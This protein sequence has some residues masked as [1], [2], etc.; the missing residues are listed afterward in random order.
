MKNG[1]KTK[2]FIRYYR[3]RNRNA[4]YKKWCERN[5]DKLEVS[6]IKRQDYRR[7]NQLGTYVDGRLVIIKVVKRPWP[8][9]CE[10]CGNEGKRLSYHHWDDN[11]MSKGLWLC[12][13]CHFFAERMDDN[14][15][16]SRYIN[17]KR[18]VREGN[19]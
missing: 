7:V 8:G 3:K 5:P 9:H 10:L 11:D 12:S 15:L 4:L 19:L 13:P 17:L 6:R 1:E 2:E 18:L 14:K 16:T